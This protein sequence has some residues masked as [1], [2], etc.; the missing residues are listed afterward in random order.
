[1]SNTSLY[2]STISEI[3]GSVG[4]LFSQLRHLYG[5]VIGQYIVPYDPTSLQSS[6]GVAQGGSLLSPAIS[7]S[8]SLISTHS[9]IAVAALILLGLAV[10]RSVFSKR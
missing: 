9:M 10:V 2:Y 1:M 6:Q 5:K 8:S 7:S 4:E 3:Q